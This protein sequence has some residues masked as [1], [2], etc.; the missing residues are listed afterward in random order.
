VFLPPLEPVSQARLHWDTQGSPVSESSGDIYFS[1]D[2]PWA[3]SQQIFVSQHGLPARWKNQS[4]FGIGE[5][6]FGF[7]VNFLATVSLWLQTRPALGWLHYMAVER[8]PVAIRDLKQMWSEL[9]VSRVL[10]EE[11]G[12]QYP[13]LHPGWH[14]LRF[15]EWRVSVTL[16]WGSL[17][18]ALQQWDT[19][20][21]AWNADGFDPSKNPEAWSPDLWPILGRLSRPGATLSSFTV[22]GWVRRGLQSA[23]FRVEKRPGFGRKRESLLATWPGEETLLP[24][25]PMTVA[26]LGGGLSGCS[27]ARSL[28]EKG[29]S[30]HLLESNNSLAQGASANRAG[31]LFPFLSAGWNAQAA[32]SLLAWQISWQLLH[33]MK[34][35]IVQPRSLLW[36]AANPEMHQRLEK[37]LA[38]LHTPKHQIEWVQT[39]AASLFPGFDALKLTPSATVDLPALC[40]HLTQSVRIHTHLGEALVSYKQT[41]D[42]WQILTNKT[43]SISNQIFDHIVVCTSYHIKSDSRFTSWPIDKIRGQVSHIKSDALAY[44]DKTI[45]CFGKYLSRAREGY[46]ELGATYERNLNEGCTLSS[47]EHNLKALTDLGHDIAESKIQGGRV[48]FRGVTPDRMPWVDQIEPGLWLNVGHGSRGLTTCPLAA[49]LIANQISQK[50]SLLP[51]WVAKRL[52]PK[53]TVG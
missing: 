32:C 50:R 28:A 17:E 21:D 20:M 29:I 37:I 22:A 6:G 10:T 35:S 1:R 27:T 52:C 14:S 36:L 13:E 19:P 30:V 25:H 45:Y 42:G 49:E 12:I 16:F 15:P 48:G 9:P 18:A 33:P 2:N 41:S 5:I 34:P 4:S 51:S 44:D 53:R 43:S 31:I 40:H 3:E 7:G 8:E 39:N 38:A 24:N 47:H 11:L 23:G 46:W 26:I